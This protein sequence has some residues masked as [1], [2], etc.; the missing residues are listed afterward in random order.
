MR[1]VLMAMLMACGG[2]ERVA[3]LEHRVKELERERADYDRRFE[4]CVN[5]I[6]AVRGLTL[7][8]ATKLRDEHEALAKKVDE[9]MVAVRIVLKR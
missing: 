5:E 8:N 7:S 1:Y 2:D 9:F 3:T 4:S 6:D